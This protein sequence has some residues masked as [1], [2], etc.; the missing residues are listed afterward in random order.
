MPG[1][2]AMVTTVA[3]LRLMPEDAELVREFAARAGLTPGEYVRNAL[4]RQ[5]LSDLS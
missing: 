5:M 4:Y 1:V 2:T 3:G